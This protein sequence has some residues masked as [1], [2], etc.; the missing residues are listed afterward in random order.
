MSL[1]KFGVEDG[2][3]NECGEDV[4]EVVGKVDKMIYLKLREGFCNKLID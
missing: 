4:G 1:D 3:G 2:I